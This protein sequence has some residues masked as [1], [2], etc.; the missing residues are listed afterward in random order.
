MTAHGDHPRKEDPYERPDGAADDTVAAVGMV[1]EA[2]EW[3]Q[4]ARGRLYDL[5]Q[6]VGHADRLFGDAAADLR[7]AGHESEAALIEREVIGRNLVRGRWTFQLVDEAETTFFEPVAA[8]ERDIRDR[9]LD[10]R[11]H[12]Y[13]AE[14]KS[15]KVTSGLEAHQARPD[16]RS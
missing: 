14:M 8:I 7:A 12:V 6:L 11:R 3:L 2:F 4:R 15:R 5:H 10:G 1:T 16:E 9:L 13:E